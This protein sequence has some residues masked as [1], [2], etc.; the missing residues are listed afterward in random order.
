MLPGK[1]KSVLIPEVVKRGDVEVGRFEI[2]RAQFAA[3]DHAYKVDPG[4]EN[5]PANNISFDQAKAYA[6]WLSKLTGQTWRVPNESEVKS[7]HENQND[8][9]TLDY[10]AGYGPNPDDTIRLQAKLKELPG[11]APLLKTVGSFPGK[12]QENE[13]LIFDAGGNVAEWTIASDGKGKLLGGSADCPADSRSTCTAASAYTGFRV[14]RGAI[15]GIPTS[16]A[17]Q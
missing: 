14:V 10:W 13:D 15:P 16:V 7:L 3:F 17:A 6:D 2:T 12:G 9:N 4:T 1:G 8:E 5:N 11:A